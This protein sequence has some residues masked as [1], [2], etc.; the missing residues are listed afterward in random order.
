MRKLLFTA[1][2]LFAYSSFTQDKDALLWTGLEAEL[3]INKKFGLKFETQSRLKSN[4]T[5]LATLYG[6]VRGSYE[7][8]NDLRLSLTYRYSRKN[9]GSYFANENRF[10]TDVRYKIDIVKGLDLRFRARY[11]H[12]FNRLTVVN[13]IPPDSKNLFRFAGSLKYKNKKIKRIQPFISGELFFP[14]GPNETNDVLDTWRTRIGID[15]DLPKRI[16]AKIFY[17]YE[18]E[19]RSIDNINHIY[20]VTLGYEFKKL[21]KKKKKGKKDD[22]QLEEK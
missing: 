7:P 11:Q 19:N 8:I 10:C 14:L 5:Q 20:C 2:F 17:M 12:A 3:P 9:R 1:F 15:L 22:P 13:E 18:Y 16:T 21:I 6:E 4:F